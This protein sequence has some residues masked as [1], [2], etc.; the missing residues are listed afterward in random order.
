MTLGAM[1]GS[2]VGLGA[3]VGVNAGVGVGRGPVRLQAREAMIISVNVTQAREA[4][5]FNMR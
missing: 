4:D 3:G 2:G 1:G 5:L